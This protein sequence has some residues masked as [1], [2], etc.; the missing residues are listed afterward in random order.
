M[1]HTLSKM[2][3]PFFKRPGNSQRFGR[4]HIS[5]IGDNDEYGWID[6]SVSFLVDCG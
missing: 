6:M 4:F 3:F 5:Y 2:C 1:T